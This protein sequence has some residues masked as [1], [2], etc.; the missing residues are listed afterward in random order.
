M[1]RS[2][3]L[4][5]VVLLLGAC[6]SDSD[7]TC[8]NVG[9]CSHGGSDDWVTHCQ[10]QNDVLADEARAVGCR[11][12]FDAYFECAAEHFECTGNESSF[13]GCEVKL[14]SYS[15]CLA[16]KEA[17][18]ACAALERELAACDPSS[19]NAASAPPAPTPCTARGDCSARCYLDALASVC[20]PTPEEL[21]TFAACADHCLF[22]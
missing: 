14:E 7:E 12:A 6:T 19:G 13:P 21:S 17:G 15:N 2:F 22:E 4:L 10:Q 20:T 1:A 9:N 3:P 18:T 5:L 11:A 8:Q 16:T